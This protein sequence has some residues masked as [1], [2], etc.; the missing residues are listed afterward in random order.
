MQNTVTPWTAAATERYKRDKEA[1]SAEGLTNKY[2]QA[3]KK[4]PW[5]CYKESTMK[6]KEKDH[7]YSRLEN[8]R[9]RKG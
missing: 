4:V 7:N 5:G 1:S 8:R 9:I 3:N 6:E 2:K